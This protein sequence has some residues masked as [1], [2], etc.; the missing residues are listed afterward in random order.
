MKPAKKKLV[1]NT[2]S[3]TERWKKKVAIKKTKILQ[4]IAVSENSGYTTEFKGNNERIKEL[5]K[6]YN[7]AARLARALMRD[8]QSY[9]SASLAMGEQLSAIGAPEKL[10][11]IAGPALVQFA[12]V[13]TTLG[14]AREEF[15]KEAMSYVNAIERFTKEEITHARRA[16]Q[17]F[18]EARIQF[19]TASS[20]LQSQLSSKTDKPLELF[21]AYTHYHYAKRKYNRRLIEASNRLSDAIEMK[22]FVVLEH[23]V[24]YMRAQLEH[25]R[26]AYEHLYN[27]DSYIT[28]LQMYIHKQREQSAE[29]KM[30]KEE[31]K[32]QRAILAE[33]NKYRPLV[34]LLA[35]PDLA[36]VGAICVSAGADQAQTL[37]TL[38]QILD[39]YKLTLPIIYIGITKEVSETDTAATLFRGNTTATKLMTAFT[40]LTG[41]PYMLATLQSLMNEFMASN[42]GYEVDPLKAKEG[43][44]TEANM[45]RLLDNCQ[46]IMDAVYSTAPMIPTPFKSMMAHLRQE[47]VKRFPDSYHKS[48]AGFIFLRFFCP[49]ILSPD[50]NGITTVPV[51]P[52]R[53]RPLVL[54]S[55]TIQNLANEVLFGQKEQFM[56]PANA[57]IEANK[58]RIHQ[59]FDEIATEP[60]NLLDYTPLQSLEQVNSKHLPD[61]HHHVVKNLTKIAQSLITYDQKESIPLLAHI[62]AQLDDESNPL[63]PQ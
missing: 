35:N 52:D 11:S 9:A 16:K 56:L 62:L 12:G 4:A 8:E 29:Q 18:R 34:E 13:Q 30:Q 53:R 6:S 45:R 42:E 44:D 5:E 21:S 17:R 36:V 51:S 2:S 38:V 59:F 55:K 1:P 37:E 58:E 28:E 54:L 40:R 15:C 31:L 7:E 23:Y 60:D 46:R 20:Q 25:L 32:R 3:V 41:R 39:A 47:C 61:I 50:S 33:Q 63:Q 14:Q 27:L 26:A 19:D 49:A 10:R 43:D 48:I 24:Q 57:F 22:E